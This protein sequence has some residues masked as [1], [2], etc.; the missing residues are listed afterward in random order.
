MMPN[1]DHCHNAMNYNNYVSVVV[2]LVL[3]PHSLDL[4]LNS[5]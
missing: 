4:T 3:N 1:W 5:E 2:T